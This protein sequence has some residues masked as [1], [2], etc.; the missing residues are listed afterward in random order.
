[1]LLANNGMDK[2][3]LTEALKYPQL[4]PATVQADTTSTFVDCT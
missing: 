2:N 1:M 3:E 4:P